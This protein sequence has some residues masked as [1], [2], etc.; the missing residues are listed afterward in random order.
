MN[1]ALATAATAASLDRSARQWDDTSRAR[2]RPVATTPALTLAGVG[3]IYT[4]PGA[5]EAIRSVVAGVAIDLPRPR[6][7]D[8][9]D[10]QARA[11]DLLGG[12][13]RAA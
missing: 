6:R 1:A 13:A 7:A 11:R 2:R 4:T 12:H 3:K 9:H 10:L 8:D 5:V